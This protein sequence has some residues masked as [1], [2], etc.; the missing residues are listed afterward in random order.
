VNTGDARIR[1]REVSE[2]DYPFL[3]A[4]YAE[5]RAPELARASWSEAEKNVF[6]VQQFTLQD[7][8]YRAHYLN[9][10]FWVI[11][12]CETSEPIGRLYR[13]QHASER[14]DRLMEISVLQRFRGC[15]IGTALTKGVMHDAAA[16]DHDVGLA[17]EPNNPAM[18][19]YER[20]GFAAIDEGEIYREM[21]WSRGRS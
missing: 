10:D 9:A 1:L 7:R 2:R 6:V 13:S 18:R 5:V 14:L 8:H 16:R 17:V 3:Q 21:R 15:G 12:W 20:L 4:L 19:L 11:E